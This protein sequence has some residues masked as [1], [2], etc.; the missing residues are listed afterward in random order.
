MDRALELFKKSLEAALAQG[1][2]TKAALHRITGISRPSIDGYLAG[3]D[4]GVG[5]VEKIAAAL[6]VEPWRLIM[7]AGEDVVPRSALEAAERR[8]QQLETELAAALTTI[9]TLSTSLGASDDVLRDIAAATK[10]EA[11]KAPRRGARPPSKKT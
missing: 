2:I 6:G 11:E 1:R 7:P 5:G 10:S 9:R 3:A 4:P 8:I